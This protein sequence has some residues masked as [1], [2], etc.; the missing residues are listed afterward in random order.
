MN[1]GNIGNINKLD[2]I[3][4]YQG[5]NYLRNFFVKALKIQKKQTIYLIN[6]S[7]LSFT[8]LFVLKQEISKYKLFMALN[9]RNK[10]ALYICEII[11]EEKFSSGEFS[12]IDLKSENARKAM[13][14]VFNTGSPD[15]GLS[16]EFEQI[17]D[18]VASVLIKEHNEKSIIPMLTEM[19]FNRNRNDKY[20]HDLVWAC[21][22]SKDINI[23]KN[24]AEHLRSPIVKDVEL[25]RS[26]LNL[27]QEIPLKTATEKEKQY[28]SFMT[29]LKDNSP[30]INFTGESFNLTSNPVPCIVD[31]ESKYLCNGGCIQVISQIDSTSDAHT[32]TK[33]E[34]SKL[35]E[36]HKAILSKYSQN[37]HEEDPIYWKEWI[38]YPIDKQIKSIQ[39]GGGE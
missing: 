2:I 31:L 10:I 11:C 20:I 12:N 21:L 36:S 34:F 5:I 6:D 33:S 16:D 26:L 1:S 13:L 17:L 27:P 3:R 38:H 39:Y 8:S 30:Y 35:P 23:L 32:N 19:I 22:Q 14:W 25:A 7:N 15:D 29:W 28:T 24:F 18:S 9:E 37:L 4:R